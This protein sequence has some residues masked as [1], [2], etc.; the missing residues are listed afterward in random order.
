MFQ[1]RFIAG[2]KKVFALNAC[3]AMMIKCINRHQLALMLLNRYA[4][5]NAGSFMLFREPVILSLPRHR[6]SLPFR[7]LS[8]HTPE[9]SI[10]PR[11][12]PPRPRLVPLFNSS[13]TVPEML[14]SFHSSTPIRNSVTP[15]PFFNLNSTPL[16]GFVD[17]Q[18]RMPEPNYDE[19]NR[20][21][22]AHN[23]RSRCLSNL[24]NVDSTVPKEAGSGKKEAKTSDGKTA[25]KFL[26]D[27]VTDH[28]KKSKKFFD[29]PENFGS[30]FETVFENEKSTAVAEFFSKS[31]P[32]HEVG[33]VKE[34]K[35]SILE[36]K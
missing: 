28:A 19:R 31:S 18:Y 30:S 14:R 35:K 3:C 11:P 23:T 33:Q 25:Q 2:S 13:S 7:P 9:C 15:P 20:L 4:F 6:T 36:V 17:L 8:Q 27:K 12:F 34:E 1:F 26:L 32:I 5:S 29:V 24:R 21:R 16:R 10:N 22:K